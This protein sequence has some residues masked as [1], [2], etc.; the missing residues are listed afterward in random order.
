VAPA[1]EA[2]EAAGAEAHR[3]GG[4]LRSPAELVERDAEPPKISRVRGA[5][6][7]LQI[8]HASIAA[9]L[10]A[11]LGAPSGM[12]PTPASSPPLLRGPPMS[13]IHHRAA[14]MED[15]SARNFE[16]KPSAKSLFEYAPGSQA[17]RCWRKADSNPRSLSRGSCLILT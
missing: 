12:V 15:V 16:A 17:T 3:P 5:P 4:E 10:V 6:D 14:A 1:G 2:C 8:G 11:V 13:S 9:C 7:H